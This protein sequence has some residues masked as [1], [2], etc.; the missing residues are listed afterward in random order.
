[1]VR[2]KVAPRARGQQIALLSPVHRRFVGGGEHIRR[3]AI[4]NLREQ[5]VRRGKVQDDF[6]PR[7]CYLEVAA[8][9]AEGIR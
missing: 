2:S 4:G 5:Q 6:H 3:C 7:M 1:L 8:N 9:V